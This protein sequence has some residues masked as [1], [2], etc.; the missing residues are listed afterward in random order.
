MAITVLILIPY[1][2]PGCNAGGPTR[3]IANLVEHLGDEI[4]LKI[5]TSDHDYKNPTPYQG[6]NIDCWNRVG[7]AKVFYCSK[8]TLSAK[9]FTDLL[10]ETEHDILYLNGLFEYNFCIKVL[11]LIK[12]SKNYGKSIIM[13]PRGVLS[14]GALSLKTRKK[15]LFLILSKF[16]NLYSNIVWHAAS[17]NELADIKNNIGEH[18]NNAH[19]IPNL[20]APF[21]DNCC[22][23]NHIKIPGNINIVLLGRISPMKNIKGA[24]SILQK[25]KGN[26]NF[27]IYGPMEDAEYWAHCQKQI[28]NMPDNISVKYMGAVDTSQVRE[29]L[30]AYDLF[31]LP[32]LGE[33]FGHV[34]IEALLASCPVL[35]SDQTPW[36]NLESKGVGWDLPLDNGQLFVSTIERIIMMDTKQLQELR[37]A[38]RKY[39]EHRSITDNLLNKEKYIKLFQQHQRQA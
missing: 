3:T 1:Y 22:T 26:I 30:S 4:N 28:N 21:S 27:H 38:T 18:A 6:I 19:M 2:L 39:A 23:E 7:K 24:L 37:T 35:I 31:F 12:L 20:S 9:H 25:V 17:N 14:K 29:T 8:N 11:L 13:A 34:I 16:L 36:R 5:V 15:K 10:N 32:T 33:N